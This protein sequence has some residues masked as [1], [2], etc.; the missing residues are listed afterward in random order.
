MLRRCAHVVLFAALF[1]LLRCWRSRGRRRSSRR[2]P[3]SRSSAPGENDRRH[4]HAARRRPRAS[5]CRSTTRGKPVQVAHGAVARRRARAARAARAGHY[6]RQA[7][8]HASAT[9]TARATDLAVRRR[10]RRRADDAR[11]HARPSRP[12]RA[13]ARVHAL[14]PRRQRRAHRHRRR[15]Q[16]SSATASAEL[17]R[18]A[19]PAPGCRMHWTPTDPGNVLALELRATSADGASGTRVTLLPW[20]RRRA[21]RRG[22]L[23]ERQGRDPPVGGAEAR[24]QLQEDHRRGGARP[25]SRPEPAG[26][27]VRR[28]PHRHRRLRPPTIASSRSRAPSAIGSWF[29]DRGLPLPIAY[30][31]FGEDAPKVKTPDETDNAANRRADYI[32]AVEEPVVAHGVRATWMKLQ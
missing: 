28:R 32:V 30:A 26:P 11:L 27:A 1:A 2:S 8:G 21:A 13:H 25:Q 31:G 17:P 29:R 18:R 7:R 5:I 4:R 16:A 10:R 24:R 3:S 20:Q 23:R 12:R 9:A 19:R 14:A 22:R 15:R 6:E